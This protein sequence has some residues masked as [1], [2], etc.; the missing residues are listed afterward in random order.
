MKEKIK[1]GTEVFCLYKGKT[2]PKKSNIANI[3]FVLETFDMGSPLFNYVFV[4]WQDGGRLL[5]R[6]SNLLTREEFQ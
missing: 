4:Y 5:A 3:G 1:V 6:K 2:E